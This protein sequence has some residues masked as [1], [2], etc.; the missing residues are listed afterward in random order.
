MTIHDGF[1]LCWPKLDSRTKKKTPGINNERKDMNVEEL[2]NAEDDIWSV[3][4]AQG[5]VEDHESL[6]N[7]ADPTF[8]DHGGGKR[9]DESIGRPSSPKLLRS[10]SQIVRAG[11]VFLLDCS[12]LDFLFRHCEE[13]QMVMLLFFFIMMSTQ[14]VP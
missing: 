1:E 3:R 4:L 2:L 8:T 11:A 13:R 9:N 10:A 5:N 12:S 14:T 7:R 6:A